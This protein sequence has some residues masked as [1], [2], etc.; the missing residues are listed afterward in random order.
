MQYEKFFLLNAAVAM[1]AFDPTGGIT[2]ASHDNMTP[3]AWTNYTDRVRATHWFEHFPE[4]DGRRLLTWKGRFSNVTNIVNFYSPQDEVVCNGNGSPV[5]IA[6]E[7]AWYNQEYRKGS[8]PFMLHEYEGGWAFNG[9]YDTTTNYWMLGVQQTETYHMPPADADQLSDAQLQQIPFFLDFHNSEIHSS[10]NGAIVV[11]NYLYRAEML[12]YAIPSESYAVGAN[13]LPGRAAMPT[14]DTSNILYCNHNMAS[15]FT[16]GQSDLPENG[17]DS[18]DKYRDWQH[19]TFVQR[20]YKRV[21]QLFKVIVKHIKE[22]TS[23]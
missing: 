23:E 7:Y 13:P 21:Y 14:N 3:Q 20:S 10:S 4:D 15:L 11:S 18:E 1:E 2:Q 17:S 5:D 16:S 22:V 8:W 19:S 6:R 12:A 9:Y